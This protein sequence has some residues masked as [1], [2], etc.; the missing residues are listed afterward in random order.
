MPQQGSPPPEYR[1]AE[2]LSDGCG[3]E[4]EHKPPTTASGSNRDLYMLS[5]TAVKGVETILTGGS[6]SIQQTYMRGNQQT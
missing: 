5:I 4:K 6:P 2:P 3:V 1:A